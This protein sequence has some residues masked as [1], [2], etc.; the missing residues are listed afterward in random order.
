MEGMGGSRDRRPDTAVPLGT[1][2]LSRPIAPKTLNNLHTL[3]SLHY[4]RRKQKRWREEPWQMEGMGG[5][6][7]RRP[8]TAVP[9]GTRCLSR[10]ISPKTINT[11]HTL[12]S[13]NF[14]FPQKKTKTKGREEPW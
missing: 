1:R 10:P 2:C 12:H 3:H 13:L 11:L 9:L 7:D 4:S 5:S 8:D 14:H 6:R